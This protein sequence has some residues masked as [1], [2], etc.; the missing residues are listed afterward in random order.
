MR[1]QDGG[2]RIGSPANGRG[3][4]TRLLRGARGGARPAQGGFLR[5][6]ARDARGNTLAIIGAA[7]VPL[8]GM[9]GSGVDMSRAYMAKTR[10]QSACDAAALA[11][12]RVMTNDTLNDT[13][14]NE[15]TRF[16][17]FNFPQ[18]LYS[19]ATFTPVVTKPT[20]GTVR[21][22]A[23]TTIPTSIMRIFGFTSLPLN[24]TCDASLNFVNTDIML[25]LDTTGSMDNDVNDNYTTTASARKI[26]ALRDAVMAM[27]DSLAG[28]QAQLEAAGMR[29]RYGIVPY[30]SSV[31]VGALIRSVNASYLTDSTPYQTRV[32]NYTTQNTSSSANGPFY[33]YYKSTAPYYTTTGSQATSITR[34]NCTNFIMNVAFTGFT[35]TPT[36]SGGPAPTPTV[37]TAFPND[38]TA[39]TG[40]EWAWSGAQDSNT[41][42][43]LASCRRQRTDTTTSYY[44]T[45]TNDNFVQSYYDTSQFKLGNAV[46]I[47]N[48]SNAN[49]YMVPDYSGSVPTSGTY[50]LQDLLT[51]GTGVQT[52]STT[53][54]GCIE[55]RDTT[56][57]ITGS[58]SGYTIPSSAFDLDINRIPSNDNTRWHPMWPGVVYTRTAGSASAT[59]GT[60]MAAQNSSYYAC[61]TAAVRLV[62][63]SGA[64]GRTNLQNYVN[65]L[66]P[67]G[68]TYHDIGMIWGAR[69]L[70][71]G[72][73]FAD[74]PNSFNGMPVSRHIIFM[75][76]GQLAPN[77]NSY[78]AYGVEQN[79]MRVTGAGTCP[80]QHDRH[81][82]RFKMVC[83]AAKS[84]NIS[85]WVIAFGTSL[86][87]DMQEC[88]SNANQASTAADRATLIARFQQIGSQIGA[89]RLTQ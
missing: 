53:W 29:L 5:R 56:N 64:T 58:A 45:Y 17:N 74:S 27:Y 16:F 21:V 89:L 71:S 33:E 25:V 84:M 43:N 72:G 52:T 26:T 67:L 24:V 2:G 40:T 23:S 38:G 3:I 30:S 51:T 86:S 19:T 37:T 13:V 42:D 78:T 66:T 15:A 60:S 39:T 1:D 8:A 79:D 34:A 31:N 59:S 75:T 18:H 32:A 80:N 50:D 73:I 20:T 81:L 10:L 47:A 63:W 65:T 70:S 9:I 69:M 41:G 46:T 4:L 22:T 77:C 44:Y 7:L 87:S 57:T 35:S 82:Q 68:G 88:A 28:T 49:A 36:S 62:A 76:D 54:N 48:P 14:T 83:N 11:G 85:I 55:E 61:P 12:R 6:L